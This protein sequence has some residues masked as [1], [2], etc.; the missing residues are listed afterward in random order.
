[1]ILWINDVGGFPNGIGSFTNRTEWCKSINR[2]ALHLDGYLHIFF[3]ALAM[4][5]FF[6]TATLRQFHLI[7]PQINLAQFD[8]HSFISQDGQ[9]SEVVRCQ[10]LW[11]N[12]ITLLWIWIETYIARSLFNK[13]SISYA[14]TYIGN[15]SLHVHAKTMLCDGKM[16]RWIGRC[17]DISILW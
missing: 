7:N 1:M 4:N 12:L 11:T 15:S 13:R 5:R 8:N 2:L 14:I 16:C 6:A 9:L 17:R 10:H 3:P